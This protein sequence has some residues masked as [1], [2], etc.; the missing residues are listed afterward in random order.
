MRAGALRAALL[1]VVQQ[2]IPGDP[3]GLSTPRK[4]G[5]RAR[6]WRGAAVM[7]IMGGSACPR[8]C[9]KQDQAVGA[10][11]LAV[12]FGQSAILSSPHEDI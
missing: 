7:V 12:S 4:R 11:L 1:D 2:S 10:R 6:A 5:D 9:V 3:W 8:L